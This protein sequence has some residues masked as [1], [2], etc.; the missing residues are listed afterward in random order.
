MVLP[1]LRVRRM[2]STLKT[3]AYALGLLSAVACNTTNGAN[4]RASA[5]LLDAGT[6]AGG[7]TF[8]VKDASQLNIVA[9]Y[10]SVAGDWM[11]F[12]FGSLWVPSSGKLVRLDPTQQ[13]VV[14]S[15]PASGNF[16]NASPTDN[17]MWVAS[18][19]DGTLYRIDAATNAVTG[20][21]SVPMATDSEGSFAVTDSGVWVVTSNGGTRS[22]T[23]TKVDRGTGQVIADITVADDSH[24]IAAQGNNV[25]VTSYSGNSV[26]EVD[27][28]TNA[29]IKVITVDS[30]PRF[31]AGG[32]NG[33]W[34][35][36]QGTGTVAHIDPSTGTVVAEI[37]A[38][39]PGSGGDIAAGGGSVWVSAFGKPVTRIDPLHDVVLEAFSGNGFGDAIRAG[40][41][42]VWVSGGSISQ[43][44]P[45]PSGGG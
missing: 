41:G 28:T 13:A 1:S 18:V 15:I 43:I 36:S 2:S 10:P 8:P 32:E 14:A 26:T 31:I 23:L 7:P 38:K 5:S 35:L 6:Q 30:G 25:W 22:G 11:C 12:A 16:C 39:T 4:G 19:F 17:Q 21:F 27:A 3:Y 29:V 37:N 33:V 24:G 42:F 34:V 9:T 44:K 45:E 20:T 40:G